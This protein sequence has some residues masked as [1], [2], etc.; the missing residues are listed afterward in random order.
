VRLR[1]LLA[2]V[3]LGGVAVIL[4]VVVDRDGG[5]AP[6]QGSALELGGRATS[7]LP[8]PV[9]DALLTNQPFLRNRSDAPIRLVSI[10]PRQTE[11]L[12][13]IGEVVGIEIGSRG[14]PPIGSTYYRTYPPV[15]YYAGR[16]TC[17][18]EEITPIEGYEVAPG[19]LVKIVV[20]FR[21]F[22]R[23][24]TLRVDAWRIHYRAGDELFYQDSEF[25]IVFEVTE[26]G[27]PGRL[28]E[29]ERRC[30]DGTQPLDA[31][32]SRGDYEAAS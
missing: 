6:A 10:E 30:L 23:P 25:G 16:D 26:R 22:D 29:S 1:I 8:V 28:T 11:G 32:L 18:T 3:V 9:G 14:S 24:G 31:V 2:A 4:L 17:G 13:S 21:T 19:A 27:E 5:D 7:R 12:G 20:V 15:E